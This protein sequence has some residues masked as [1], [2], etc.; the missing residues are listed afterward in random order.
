VGR[1]HFRSTAFDPPEHDAGRF[2]SGEPDLDDWL[3]MHAADAA[4][5]RVAR[6]FAWTNDGCADVVA[7]YALSAHAI[8]RDE[9]PSKIGRGV[10]DPVPA[11]MVAKL[12]LDRSLRGQGLGEALLV[13][14]LSRIIEASEAG[15]AVRAI[16]VDAA[17]EN[18]RSLYSRFGFVAAPGRE[19]RMIIRAE[20]VAKAIG[21]LGQ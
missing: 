17:T 18:A 12:A 14:A 19:D 20:T 1:P 13:D 10:P 7:Y 21:H 5:A 8:P 4:R 16:V 2:A 3:K 15:P 11:A 9:A 6:T